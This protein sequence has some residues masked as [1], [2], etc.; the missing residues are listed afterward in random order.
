[1]SDLQIDAN[2]PGLGQGV[3]ETATTAEDYGFD[4]VWTGETSHDAFLPLPLAAEYTD[5]LEVG[6]NIALS[7]TRS[8]MALAYMAWDLADY[9]DGRFMLGLGTQV[10]GHNERRFS[11]SFDW[12]SPGPRLREVVES[13]KHIFDVFQGEADE[14]D[15]QGE[16]YQ[17]SLMTEF[18]NP[19]P[20]DN[21]EIPIY[22]AG[23]NEYNLRTA[24]R[25]GDGLAMH[26]FN[27]PEYT[28]EVVIPTVREGAERGGR[29]FDE[30]E[31][32]ATP[33]L[34]TGETD[35][36]IEE[37]RELIRSQIAFYASTRTYHTILEHYGWEDTGM[38]LHELSKENRF[39]EMAELV[40]D[41]MVDTFAVQAPLTDLVDE[42]KDTYGGIADRIRVTRLEAGRGL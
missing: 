6:T 37:S 39:G 41:E 20:I 32:V 8:P 2:L 31:L 21:P 13:I 9:T 25:V 35:E 5:N 11:V 3:V 17:F 1:M 26:P 36:E 22:V 30:I 24:G 23:V 34:I 28:E 33:L 14:L 19:G 7:F 27:T 40:T 42:V 10:K 12:E 29:S 38:E 16:Y 15:Y 4:G 18:F